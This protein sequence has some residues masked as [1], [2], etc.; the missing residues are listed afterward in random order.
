MIRS[1]EEFVELRSSEDPELYRRAANEVA[2]DEVWLDV[3]QRYPE[4][5]FWVAQNKTVS[6]RILERL[7]G[8]PD[9]QVRWM[10][11]SK[12]KATAAMLEKLAEDANESVRLAVATNRSTPRVVLEKL[13]SDAWERVVE[14]AQ[15]RLESPK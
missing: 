12:R 8:D 13:T 15:Q 6:M 9:D 11:A 3:I 4:M 7:M 1:A 14:V 5:K 10:V 2:P